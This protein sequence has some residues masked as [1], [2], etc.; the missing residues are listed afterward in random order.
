MLDVRVENARGQKRHYWYTAAPSE[1]PPIGVEATHITNRRHALRPG[2]RGAVILMDDFTRAPVSTTM[3]R[4]RAQ[5][6]QYI[7]R[8]KGPLCG[9]VHVLSELPADIQGRFGDL[10]GDDPA[11]KGFGVAIEREKAHTGTF[12]ILVA[13]E[14]GAIIGALGP[15]NL[16]RDSRGTLRLLP[17]Y[18]VVAPHRRNQGVGTRLWAAMWQWAQQK[19][20][21]YTL[22]QAEQGSVAEL[23][24]T[25][26]HLTVLGYTYTL[27]AARE[28]TQSRPKSKEH[29]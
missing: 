26:Q 17:C 5:H 11:L 4:Q 22:L 20:A 10:L 3:Q 16:L 1:V 6:T 13:V 19:G 7:Q 9:E 12:P 15:L 2:E 27:N 28:N 23:F 25:A 24:Y 29:L 18:F 21:R 14:E 8:K